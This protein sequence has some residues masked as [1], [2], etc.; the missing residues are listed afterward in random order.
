MTKVR[1]EVYM[2]WNYGGSMIVKR[3]PSQGESGGENPGVLSRSNILDF[4]IYF[5]FPP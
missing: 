4:Q 3:G 5:F 1:R 2:Y